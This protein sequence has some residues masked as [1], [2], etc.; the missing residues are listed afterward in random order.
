MDITNGFWRNKKVLITGHTGFKGSWLS[1]WLTELG[2]EV[3]GIA[4]APNTTPNH[5]ELLKLDIRDHQKDIRN[6]DAILKIINQTNPDII[7]HL[8]AQP[9]VRRSYQDPLE[10]WST[11]VMG[12]ANILEAARKT[13][14]IKAIVI[15]TTDKCYENKEWSWG[16]REIDP[17]GGHD[18]YSSS[19]AATE[20]VAASYR[21]SFFNQ[22]S[23]PMLA[24]ARAGNVIG[25]GDWS[26][27]R[28][29][30]DLVRAISAGQ[31]LEIRS[32]MATR[33]WQHVLESLRGYLLLGESLIMRQEDKATA[34]NF[35]PDPEGNKT[36]KEVLTKLSSHWPELQWKHTDNLHPH[37]ANLLY[38][39]STKSKIQ[40]NWQP[41]WQLDQ[42]IQATSEWY[43]QYYSNKYISSR[44]QLKQYV[45]AIQNLTED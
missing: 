7:F 24:T 18:P 20:F 30:P 39:D 12:T 42:A 28:L 44:D 5:W 27:D 22:S 33:P 17:L 9:L 10:T 16:Y 32:P 36:V 43:R 21:Q 26:S 23:S 29:I 6:S 2:A 1:L 37:E 13:D 38:L 8:A 11:N 4:L 45:T 31:P 40:L 19:K 3:T 25:G 15:I 35:G 41:V 14:N 34:W